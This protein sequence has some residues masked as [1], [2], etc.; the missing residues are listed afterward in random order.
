MSG[1][2]ASTRLLS[3]LA[4]R[5]VRARPG[6]ALLTMLSVVIGVSGVVAVTTATEATHQAYRDM[7]AAMTGRAA[8]EVVSER[9]G[10]CPQALVEQ[11]EAIPGVRA[12]AP[13]VQRPTSMYFGDSRVDAMILG[14]DPA[15]HALVHDF[16][17]EAG[18]S[19]E[20]EDGALLDASFARG[21]GIAVGD[22]IK[23]FTRSGMRRLNVVGLLS[24][25]S[26]AAAMQGGTVW[27]RLARGQDL[28][29]LSERIDALH[30]LLQEGIDERAIDSEVKNL[31]PSGVIVRR[32][33][34]RSQQVQDRMLATQ[35]G[36]NVGCAYTLLASAFIILNTFLMNVTERRRQL[37]ILRAI[38]ATRNQVTQLLLWEG[39]LLG[40]I[41]TILGLGVGLVGASALTQSMGRL[42]MASLPAIAISPVSLALGT[43][44]G[45]G[46]ALVATWF[47]ARRAARVSPIEG[48]R[49]TPSETANEGVRTMTRI[50][51]PMG[52][53]GTISM[54]AALE[55][56]IPSMLVIPTGFFVLIGL[57]LVIPAILPPLLGFVAGLISPVS[58]IEGKIAR[59]QLGRW[60]VRTSLTL[61]VVFVALSTG[62]GMGNSILSSVRDVRDWFQITLS[63]H[64]FVRGVVPDMVSGTAAEMPDSYREQLAAIS[65]VRQIDP[66]RF[67]RSTAKDESVLIVVRELANY[68]KLPLELNEGEPDQVTRDLLAG[69]VVLGSVLAHRTGLKL[70]DYFELGTDHGP[71]RVRVAG[72]ATD[73][74]VGG[75]LLYMERGAARK[76]L[77]ITGVDL[78]LVSA[79]EEALT[80][81]EAALVDLCH[82]EG[83]LL[84]SFADLSRL[85]DRI[86]G[87]V[88]AGLWAIL[89]LEFIVAGFGIANTLTMNVLEQTREIGLLRVVAMTRAQ[90]RRMIFSQAALI[91]LS[92]VTLGLPGG[93][94]VA[95]LINICTQPVT[96]QPVEF[97]MHPY[98]L[99]GGCVMSLAIVAL[100]AWLPAE[101]AVRLEPSEA[102]AYE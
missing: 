102:L 14:V 88:E 84:Q 58:G 46:I 27:V 47:P 41:G 28:F 94:I 57:I 56:W 85:V 54:I 17:I 55:N 4:F 21:A 2:Q 59:G 100:A 65:G 26:V 67:V 64:F 82:R 29:R 77:D 50:G 25:R 96:G 37:G 1:T 13:L 87:G 35:V 51:L 18:A 10:T 91:G 6:R 89:A 93:L 34:A 70:G 16:Q 99:L 8:M 69:D 83:L 62:V 90:V 45:M 44:A 30:I 72:V 7:Y 36:L 74:Q 12:A 92:A 11:V 86:M 9:G 80:D 31:L 19:L 40:A 68:P 32:P 101:R 43:L 79:D 60:R 81:V 42:F 78:F 5:Q 95:W 33:E 53:A 66:V 76:V 52:L 75:M 71:Q 73:Y 97:E 63:A 3:L 23:V 39:L 15:R 20:Q 98:L 38:G 61:G 22:E 48:M 24:P 49:R